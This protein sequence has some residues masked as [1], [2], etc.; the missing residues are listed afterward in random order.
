MDI[1]IAFCSLVLQASGRRGRC[2]AK[3][4]EAPICSTLA[5]FSSSPHRR[6]LRIEQDAHACRKY[7]S[8][9]ILDLL[10]TFSAALQ[11]LTPLYKAI[12][13]VT[14]AFSIVGRS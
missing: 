7:S 12:L 6:L 13:A 8:E 3:D 4:L 10:L 2:E 5:T 14:L 11:T 1:S 9:S